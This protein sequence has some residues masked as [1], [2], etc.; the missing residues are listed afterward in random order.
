MPLINIE[1]QLKTVD[2]STKSTKLGI[3]TEAGINATAL[4]YEAQATA[5]GSIQLGKGT[6]SSAGTL[7]VG[8]S[9]NGTTYNEYELLSSDGKI[10]TERLASNGEVGQVLKKTATGMEWADDSSSVISKAVITNPSLTTDGEHC[11]WTITNTVSDDCCLT[12][13][14]ITSGEEIIGNVT[15]GTGTIT[16]VLNSTE[17]ISADTYKAVIIG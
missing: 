7:A 17:N 16:V 14:E 6:N 12:I 13:K 10:P 15:F 9:T 8:L 4:G 3:D 2:L 11:T 1:H 5:T